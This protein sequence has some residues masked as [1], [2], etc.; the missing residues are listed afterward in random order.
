M[1]RRRGAGNGPDSGGAAAA[2]AADVA[3]MLALDR[4]WGHR[5]GFVGWLTTTDHKAIGLRF[6]GTAFVFFLLGGILALVMR[7]Q[8][9]R[10]GNTAVGSLLTT[11]TLPV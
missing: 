2:S 5:P 8:L 1:A 6:V 11:V 3:E 9:A 4:T 7:L 10:P